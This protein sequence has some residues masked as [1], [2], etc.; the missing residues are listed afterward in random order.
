M[1]TFWANRATCIRPMTG[2]WEAFIL[3]ICIL[4]LWPDR[5]YAI[6]TSTPLEIDNTTRQI[7]VGKYLSLLE[8][9]SGKLTLDQVRSSEQWRLS[10]NEEPNFGFTSSAWWARL[11]LTF[12][13]THNGRYYLVIGDAILNH[14]DV[15]IAQP[16]GDLLHYRGGGMIDVA[17]RNQHYRAHAFVLPAVKSREMEVYIRVAS[18]L[19]VIL[20]LRVMESAEFTETITRETWVQALYIGFLSA[21]LI[22]NATV[23]IRMKQPLNLLYCGFS[24]AMM[25]IGLSFSGFGR[26]FIWTG[27]PTVDNAL[28]VISCAMASLFATIFN[29]RFLYAK[30]ESIP[31]LARLGRALI[32]LLTLLCIVFAAS[33]HP[34]KSALLASLCAVCAVIYFLFNTVY[35]I[36]RRVRNALLLLAAWTGVLIG[37][38]VFA[39]RALGLLPSN[40]VT[41][42]ALQFSTMFECFLLMVAI[43][44]KSREMRTE[45]EQ[46][47]ENAER[48]LRQEVER[49]TTALRLAQQDLVEQERKQA[50]VIFAAGIAHEINNP[51]NFIAGGAQ[52]ASAVLAGMHGLFVE[53]LDDEA[54]PVIRSDMDQHF[55]DCLEPLQRMVAGVASMT[56]AVQEL[57]RLNPEGQVSS[58]RLRL[59]P[60]LDAACNRVLSTFSA[61][62][63]VSL[64]VDDSVMVNGVFGELNTIL[65][66]LLTNALEAILSRGDGERSTPG[67]V[68][69]SA[70]IR[71]GRVDV[72]IADN[73]PGVDS[74]IRDDIFEPF[75]S[76]RSRADGAGLGLS[77][78]RQTARRHGGDLWID[79]TFGNG[80]CMVLTLPRCA[81]D[82][83]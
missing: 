36:R 68:Q 13:Q 81:T 38:L 74:A 67:E 44:E 58:E 48:R 51:A 65:E 70:E 55:N 52:Q 22:F 82:A 49:R 32:S 4:F 35:A 75:F 59:R 27:S 54:D 21:M 25:L 46:A 3:L 6:P 64:H 60:L 11:T 39:G 37:V 57:R 29:D 66:A 2:S 1:R 42:Y 33:G 20:P 63:Q 62:L 10:D 9:T 26:M 73:G 47:T 28:L 56:G 19:A 7:V 83:A 77:I 17:D 41:T 71:A 69:I 53:M 23:G 80:C 72:R 8:D 30:N 43:I 40:L 16:D 5:T 76:T 15:F 18:E 61:E 78:S 79:E 24:S 34:E 12:N 14:V 45:L 50:M 31:A